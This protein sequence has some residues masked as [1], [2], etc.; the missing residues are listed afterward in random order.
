MTPDPLDNAFWN[1]LLSRP[2]GPAIFAKALRCVAN[3]AKSRADTSA[4]YTPTTMPEYRDTPDG[5]VAAYAPAR[6]GPFRCDHC[7]HSTGESNALQC[8]KTEMVTESKI[9]RGLPRHAL[10][11]PVEDGGCCNYFKPQP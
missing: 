2:D 3:N 11:A 1:D 8:G 5:G 10:T 9:L 4:A 6:E 7:R